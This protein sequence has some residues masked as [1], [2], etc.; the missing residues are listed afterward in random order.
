MSSG[1]SAVAALN[2]SFRN[3]SYQNPQEKKYK[4]KELKVHHKEALK[5]IKSLRNKITFLQE[6][7]DSQ[8]ME[9]YDHTISNISVGGRFA[10]GL[11][12]DKVAVPVQQDKNL[13]NSNNP[14]VMLPPDDKIASQL[15][16]TVQVGSFTKIKRAQKLTSHIKQLLK[17]E[18]LNDL[19][20]E[21][22]SEHYTVRLG[23]FHSYSTAKKFLTPIKSQMPSAIILRAYFI[24]ERILEIYKPQKEIEDVKTDQTR[25]KDNVLRSEPQDII[26]PTMET[27]EQDMTRN[28]RSIAMEEKLKLIAVYFHKK[29]YDRALVIIKNEFKENPRHPQLNSWYGAVLMKK[30]KSEEALIYLEEAIKLSPPNPTYHNL[31]GYCLLSLRKTNKAINEFETVLSLEH[32]HLDALFGLGFI[33]AINRNQEKAIDVYNKLKNLDNVS[34]D[35]L[36]KIIN[37]VHEGHTKNKELQ[38]KEETQYGIQAYETGVDIITTDSFEQELELGTD[39]SGKQEEKIITYSNKLG[40]TKKADDQNERFFKIGRFVLTLRIDNKEPVDIV[41]NILSATD[42]I[43]CFFEAIDIVKDTTVKIVWYYDEK[44]ISSVEL[45]IHKGPRWRTFSS[46]KLRGLNGT[47]NVEL[48]DVNGIVLDN[49]IFTVEH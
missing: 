29:D 1:M 25:V 26:T 5:E 2:L 11:E 34:A 45:P 18:G 30:G 48:Q 28:K 41:N 14:N 21:K 49:V 31:F 9:Q 12:L 17:V 39:I 27:T 43:Y 23:K 15:I 22:L 42:K 6:K 36:F 47:W 33:Y 3:A 38:I 13:L 32:G 20:I 44:E 40:K 7:T 46:K 35:K 8:K 16:Y 24:E 37:S 19:R 10:Q 4:L